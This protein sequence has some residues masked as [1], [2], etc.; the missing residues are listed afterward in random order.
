M[1]RSSPLLV[2]AAMALV[3]GACSGDSA[4][5]TT[6]TI[7]ATTTAPTTTIATTTSS[8]LPATTTTISSIPAT[9]T[10]V[11]VQQDL[12]VLGFFEGTVDG[13]AGD[14]TKAA[15]AAFQADAG[16]EAD[17]EF[18]PVTDAAMYPQLQA[19]EE[20]VM[21]VQEQLEELGLYSGPIDGDFGRGTQAAVE[22]FQA[23][24]GL[25]ET[26]ELEIDTRVCLL[27]A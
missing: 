25:E 6:T 10:I 15:I 16:I 8:T 24:C 26:G 3:L 20:Y 19:N 7:A 9:A 5:E 22:K 17:G 2:V 13:I 14:E 1:R 18:G 12:I 11:V 4:E 27:E 23:D 21:D